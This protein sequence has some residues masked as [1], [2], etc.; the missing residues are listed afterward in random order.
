MS[1]QYTTLG[2]YENKRSIN[3][4][5]VRSHGG[6]RTRIFS[7]NG[8]SIIVHGCLNIASTSSSEGRGG[9]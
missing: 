4:H 6:G 1:S 3:S 7:Q 2:D 9:V 5:A 8:A